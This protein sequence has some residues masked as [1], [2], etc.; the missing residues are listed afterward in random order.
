MAKQGHAG[1]CTEPKLGNRFPEYLEGALDEEEARE[2]TAHVRQCSSCQSEMDM[3]LML[4]E[5]DPSLSQEFES[6]RLEELQPSRRN[7]NRQPVIQPVE[8]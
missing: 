3:W 1:H 6:A 8:T 4:H 5:P 7:R 2:I